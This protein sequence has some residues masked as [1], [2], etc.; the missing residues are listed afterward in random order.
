MIIQIDLSLHV[1]FGA[2]HTNGY[3]NG[4]LP[5]Q[6]LPGTIYLHCL[7]FVIRLYQPVSFRR[8]VHRLHIERNRLCGKYLRGYPYRIVA[9]GHILVIQHFSVFIVQYRFVLLLKILALPVQRYDHP[10]MIDLL[11]FGFTAG[12]LYDIGL[13]HDIA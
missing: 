4:F 12:Y 1:L 7:R 13:C 10:Y 2:G 5:A 11:E 3:L 8:T 9:K 6:R